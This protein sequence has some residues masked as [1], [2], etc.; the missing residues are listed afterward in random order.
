MNSLDEFI[1]YVGDAQP[2]MYDEMVWD[3]LTYDQKISVA[4]LASGGV[5]AN[6]S[7][8]EEAEEK[9]YAS[10]YAE[11][12]TEGEEAALESP[13]MTDKLR[14]RLREFLG[15]DLKELV[16]EVLLPHVPNDQR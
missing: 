8:L 11:G 4:K 15:F 14:T 1:E 13:E 16:R 10:G 9:G 6:E 7:K 2:T 12:K 3:T 5:E